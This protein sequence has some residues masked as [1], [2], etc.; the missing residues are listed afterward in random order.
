MMGSPLIKSHPVLLYCECVVALL[1]RLLRVLLL[2][3]LHARE[4]RASVQTAARVELRGHVQHGCADVELVP[5]RGGP[6]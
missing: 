6:G 4:H 5:P 3:P 1:Y 2:V